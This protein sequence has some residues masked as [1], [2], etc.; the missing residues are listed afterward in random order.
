MKPEKCPQCG[1]NMVKV[2]DGIMCLECNVTIK[3][4]MK[5]EKRTVLEKYNLNENPCIVDQQNG[6]IHDRTVRSSGDITIHEK[7][8]EMDCKLTFEN[9]EKRKEFEVQLI[10]LIQ[11]YL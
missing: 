6:S 2:H 9:S 10:K 5:L 4:K 11:E 7:S 1:D 8:V 3:D